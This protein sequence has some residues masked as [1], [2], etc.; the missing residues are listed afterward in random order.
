MSYDLTSQEMNAITGLRGNRER[1]D[2]FSVVEEL[3]LKALDDSDG[4]DDSML[5]ETLKDMRFY[6]C[7]LSLI[8]YDDDYEQEGGTS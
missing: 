7:M 3:I 2:S 6:R 4:E 8:N 1:L 5:I